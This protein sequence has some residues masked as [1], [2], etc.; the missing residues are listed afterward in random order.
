M[1]QKENTAR[2]A[3]KPRRPPLWPW[4]CL[5]LTVLFVI[6]V[7]VRLLPV[8]LERDEG[9]YA[10]AGQLIL[11]GIPPY[12]LVYNV[13]FPG[14]YAAYALLMAVFG[15]TPVGI[16]LGLLVVNLGAILLLF[17]L[18]RRLFDP[19]AAAITSATYA[20]MSISPPVVG[21]A[22]H[23]THFVIVAA[24]GGLVLLLRALGSGR[25]PTFFTSGLLFGIALLMKQPGVFFGA[26]AFMVL[27]FEQG[28]QGNRLP[29]HAP[30]LESEPTGRPE[31]GATKGLAGLKVRAPL[32]RF[33]GARRQTG[34]GRFHLQPIAVFALGVLTPVALTC[35]LLWRAGVFEKFWRW[36]VLYASGHS[37][38]FSFR[39]LFAYFRRWNGPDIVFW[40]FALIGL[41][42]LCVER[43]VPRWTKGFV[44]GFLLCSF[45]AVCAGF[46]FTW[47]YFVLLLPAV[48]LLVGAGCAVA[49]QRLRTTR[50]GQLG[51]ALPTVVFLVASALILAKHRI[52]FFLES[53]VDICHRTYAGNPFVEAQA[54]ADYIRAHSSSDIRVAVLGSEPEIYFYSH[55]HSATGYIYMYDLA[56][57]QAHAAEMQQEMFRE[58]EA[59]RPEFV[60]FL[61]NRMSWYLPQSLKDKTV[62][63]WLNKYLNGDFRLVGLA[64]HFDDR[65]IYR[66]DQEVA[67]YSPASVFYLLLF[68]R[69]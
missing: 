60:I 58:I 62:V 57:T 14:T 65:I 5:A 46:Y 8:P 25:L 27:L 43:T 15:Q 33:F 49:R 28:P 20:L 29:A 11:E 7:R 2:P 21:F 32:R 3:P 47:H 56:S 37:L 1:G 23:A 9:E 36:T 38:P 45:L 48:G 50:L 6:G 35:L 64:D 31:S 16:H 59:A 18:A 44:A 55:R 39:W 22:A 26:F 52:Y 41:L 68:Q 42:V 66:W 12:Q 10:Y 19:Y 53:P 63:Q 30:A 51:A 40:C 13:K 34:S 54:V 69:K 17:F 24:L 4:V 61:H 67:G